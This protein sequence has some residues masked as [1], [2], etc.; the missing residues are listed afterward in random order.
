METLFQEAQE[1]VVVVSELSSLA[2]RIICAYW[3]RY[4]AE[5]LDS[6]SYDMKLLKQIIE[7]VSVIKQGS[8]IRKVLVVFKP[9]SLQTQLAF[10]SLPT[11][12]K[13]FDD[14]HHWFA[15]VKQCLGSKGP[16]EEAERLLEMGRKIGVTSRAEVG[17]D[18]KR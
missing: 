16:L 15:S 12:R 8:A 10:A 9:R 13:F 6:I 4:T 11:L 14:S 5:Q 7:D 2:A 1:R 17:C 18:G 3:N